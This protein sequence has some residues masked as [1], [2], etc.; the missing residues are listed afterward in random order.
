MTEG[1]VHTVYSGGRWTNRIEGA[2]PLPGWHDRQ[3][4]PAEAGGAHAMR[5]QAEHVIRDEDGTIAQRVS[6]GGDRV[7]S[8]P[9]AEGENTTGLAYA[10]RNLVQYLL[11]DRDDSAAERRAL[12][13]D[14]ALERRVSSRT[15]AL[16]ESLPES[17]GG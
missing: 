7:Y 3:E 4:I 13:R 12:R 10:M 9:Q 5:S 15:S 16:P 17:A 6:Y 2:A 14:A 8:A 1:R 11:H